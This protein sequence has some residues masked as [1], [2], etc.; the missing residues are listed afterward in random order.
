MFRVWY[1]VRAH[2]LG[3]S[4]LYFR[5][6]NYSGDHSHL[7][8]GTMRD[9]ARLSL[10][11]QLQQRNVSAMKATQ[12]RRHVSHQMNFLLG[13]KAINPS[14]PRSLMLDSS[15]PTCQPALESLSGS[16]GWPPAPS[17]IKH[18]PYGLQNLLVC[19]H[20]WEFPRIRVLLRRILLFFGGLLLRG[21]L[22][23]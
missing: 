15:L 18:G 4:W 13:A 12:S 1:Q 6:L 7:A 19:A 16:S 23:F 10:K 17:S 20:M 22:L 21:I 2:G 3:T 14:C 8:C 11:P 9:T 5:R